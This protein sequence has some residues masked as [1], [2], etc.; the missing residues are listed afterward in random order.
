MGFCINRETFNRILDLYIDLIFFFL[1]QS[2]S[3]IA[4]GMICWKV[5][6]DWYC[7]G[8]K[9]RRWEG[10]D[11]AKA[12]GVAYRLPHSYRPALTELPSNPATT[13]VRVHVQV[14]AQDR[15]HRVDPPL[16]ARLQRA[17]PPQTSFLQG[18]DANLHTINDVRVRGTRKKAPWHDDDEVFSY[19]GDGSDTSSRGD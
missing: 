8:V 2:S 12:S 3:S 18:N 13:H 4:N 19:R 10:W 15:G 16:R 6:K 11:N 1:R 17:F 9:G 5:H 7:K 14:Q